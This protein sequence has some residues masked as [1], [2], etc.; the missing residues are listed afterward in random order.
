MIRPA[1][2]LMPTGNITFC[3]DLSLRRHDSAARNNRRPKNNAP[4]ADR[5]A[6]A[7]CRHGVFCECAG[8]LYLRPCTWHAYAEEVHGLPDYENWI[9]AKGITQRH[10][11]LL[12]QCDDPDDWAYL[13]IGSWDHPYYDILGWCWGRE[14]KTAPIRDPIGECGGDPRPC[15][16]VPQDA[17]FMKSPV[18]LY[19]ELRRRQALIQVKEQTGDGVNVGETD[20]NNLLDL[21]K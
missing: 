13:L 3:E 17:P 5:W 14:A 9:D 2:L 16:F 10:H 11:H 18:S 1:R 15:H 20:G 7:I 12:V 8:W 4:T 6:F 19:D 21:L